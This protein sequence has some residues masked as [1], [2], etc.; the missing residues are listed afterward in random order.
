MRNYK[1]GL[2]AYA[3]RRFY[4]GYYEYHTFSFT[5]ERNIDSLR[6]QVICV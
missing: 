6:Y 3:F 2:Y 1:Q 4:P 5:N